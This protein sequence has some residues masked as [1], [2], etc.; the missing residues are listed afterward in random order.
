MTATLDA[1]RRATTDYRQRLKRLS[2]RLEG[3]PRTGTGADDQQ[4]NSVLE[5]RRA[6]AEC[7]AEWQL[8]KWQ[9]LFRSNVHHPARSQRIFYRRVST[10]LVDNTVYSLHVAAGQE[11]RRSRELAEDMRDGWQVV[12]H[13]VPP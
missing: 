4:V 1:R 9:A 13:Q 3:A 8:K 7:K 2:D 10:K 12:M 6:V 5:T 11:R